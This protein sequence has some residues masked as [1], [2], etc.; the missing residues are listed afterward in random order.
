MTERENR[1]EGQI[2][3]KKINDFEYVTRY[4]F[5]KYRCSEDMAK[6]VEKFAPIPCRFERRVR[7]GSQ[8]SPVEPR[9]PRHQNGTENSG[10]GSSVLAPGAV[11]RDNCT[12]QNTVS[13][14]RSSR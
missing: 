2:N 8:F 4:L 14:G 6:S 13:A 5:E 12:C 7:F 11:C 3:G 10:N 9:G 1:P